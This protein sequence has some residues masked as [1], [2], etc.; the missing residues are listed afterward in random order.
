V[1]AVLSTLF[2]SRGGSGTA[3]PGLRAGWRFVLFAAAVVAALQVHEAVL[4]GI[5]ATA[6][7]IDERPFALTAHLLITSTALAMALGLTAIV[8]RLERRSFAA[9]GLPAGSAFGRRFWRGALWGVAMAT[10]VLVAT[11]LLGGISFER[12][13]LPL[14]HLAVYGA[15][16]AIGFAMIAVSEELLFRGYPLVA[17]GAAIRFWPA[18]ALLACVFGALHLL[19]PGENPVGALGVVAYALFASFTLRRTGD[20]W[21]AVGVHAGWDFSLSYFYGVADSGTLAA[22]HILQARVHGPAWLTGGTA[23]PEGSAPGFAIL[24]LACFGFAWR[25]P[26]RASPQPRGQRQGRAG[27]PAREAAFPGRQ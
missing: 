8:A 25:S 16:W 11:W 23:G 4:R 15:G 1:V 10:L 13:T 12:P 20:L 18:A 6:A 26:A 22:Q 14:V 24:V 7:M 5:P 9:Y 19:N 21:F 2:V 27:E 3:P 17:L